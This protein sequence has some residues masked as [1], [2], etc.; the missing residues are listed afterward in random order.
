MAKDRGVRND[1][2]SRHLQAVIGMIYRGCN[3]EHSKQS[4]PS[5]PRFNTKPPVPQHQLLAHADDSLHGFHRR[6]AQDA[7]LPLETSAAPRAGALVETRQEKDLRR[8][9]I[10]SFVRTRQFL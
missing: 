6:P 7:G 9:S 10:H 5:F 2:P 4:R 3:F 8:D 1:A